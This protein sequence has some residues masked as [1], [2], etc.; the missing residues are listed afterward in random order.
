LILLRVCGAP[1]H[2]LIQAEAGGPVIS[3][4]PLVKRS[5]AKRKAIMAIGVCDKRS[6]VMLNV[7]PRLL[8]IYIDMYIY[9]Y[10]HVYTYIYIYIYI[11]IYSYKCILS[12]APG[13]GVGGG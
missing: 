9:T 7:V 12:S 10:I 1:P 8:H 11:G 3:P 5:N 4:R 2:G 13:E 6:H